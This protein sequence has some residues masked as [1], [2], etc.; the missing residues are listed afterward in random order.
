[1]QMMVFSTPR[2]GMEEEY[3]KWYEEVHIP[4][5]LSIPGMKSCTR[6]RGQSVAGQPAEFA[7]CA[8]YEID[9]DFDAIMREMQARA[10]DGRSQLSPAIDPAATKVTVWE[11]L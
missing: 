11:P 4:D 7:Y 2:A 8:V 1:M 6:F 9:G 3:N 5:L 10:A